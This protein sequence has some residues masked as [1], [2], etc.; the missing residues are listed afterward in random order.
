MTEIFITWYSGSE[1]EMYAFF[2]NRITGD[3]ALQFWTMFIFNAILP[4]LFWSKKIRRNILIVFIISLLINVGMWFERF[5]IVI[6]SLTKYYL[7]SNWAEYH[8]TWVE[9]GFYVGTLGMFAAGILLFFRYIPQIAIHEVKMISKYNKQQTDH[10][11]PGHH[12][13]E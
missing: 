4:Q 10:L 7:P 12:D 1:Y 8:P 6:T 13:Y 3:Y 5:N 11:K 9:V 2:K